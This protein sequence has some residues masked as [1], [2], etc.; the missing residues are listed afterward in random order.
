LEAELGAELNERLSKYSESYVYFPSAQEF[1]DRGFSLGFDVN[2]Q[3]AA[4]LAATLYEA[5]DENGTIDIA[6]LRILAAAKLS[7]EEISLLED[8]VKRR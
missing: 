4:D 1:I 2:R 5:R 3:S 7:A 8:V 6:K